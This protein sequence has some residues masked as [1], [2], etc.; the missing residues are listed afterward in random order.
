[1]KRFKLELLN[2]EYQFLNTGQEVGVWLKNQYAMD[3]ILKHWFRVLSYL[4]HSQNTIFKKGDVM[5]L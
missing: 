2:P 5:D 1:M 4:R 3:K